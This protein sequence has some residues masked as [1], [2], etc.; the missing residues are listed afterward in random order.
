MHKIFMLTLL[1]YVLALNA[2][3]WNRKREKGNS[4]ETE[5]PQLSLSL[6]LFLSPHEAI[7]L[8]SF[9]SRFFSAMKV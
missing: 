4:L 6:S 1:C 2:V 5:I 9:H 7:I 8:F 3:Q